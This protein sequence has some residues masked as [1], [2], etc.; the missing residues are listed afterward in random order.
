[1]YKDLIQLNSKKK[2]PY[3]LKM[4]RG[5]EQTFFLRCLF[6]Q[7]KDK[8]LHENLFN[9]VNNQR[10]ANQKHSEPSLHIC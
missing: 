6:F 7:T 4:D 1:M 5:S 2:K 10:N 8:Q 9:I 3:N